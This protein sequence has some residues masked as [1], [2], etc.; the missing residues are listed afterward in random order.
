MVTNNTRTLHASKLPRTM[1]AGRNGRFHFSILALFP[2]DEE[3]QATRKVLEKGT[4]STFEVSFTDLIAGLYISPRWNST[5]LTLALIAQTEVGGQACKERLDELKEGQFT[6]DM[7]VMMGVCAGG[8]NVDGFKE[9]GTVVIAKSTAIEG[10][11]GSAGRQD[12]STKMKPSLLAAINTVVGAMTNPDVWLS[13]GVFPEVRVPSP[14]YVMEVIMQAMIDNKRKPMLRRELL[15]K[16]KCHKLELSVFSALLKRMMKEDRLLSETSDCKL[17]LTK[18]GE[19]YFARALEFPR[20][21][22]VKVVVDTI[23]TLTCHPDHFDIDLID[24]KKQSQ[25]RVRGLDLESH[26]F[27]T[28]VISEFPDSLTLVIKGISDFGQPLTPDYVKVYATSLA[29]AAFKY[30]LSQRSVYDM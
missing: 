16:L 21:D 7:A 24:N 19:E 11:N 1:A 30:L 29:A 28:H 3:L 5:S 2:T 15:E 25:Q 9:Y 14:R 17:K 20:P 8:K 23:R 13:R 10:K 12:Q 22:E 26:Q 4:D 6:F 27:T 18:Q